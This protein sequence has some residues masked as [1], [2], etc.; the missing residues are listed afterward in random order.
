[1]SWIAITEDDVKTRLAGAELAAYKSA[2]LAQ[3][4]A[5]PLPEV[6][7]QVVSEVR[8]YIAANQRNFLSL[9]ELIPDKLLSATLA[10]IRYRLL[11]RL[12]IPV[13]EDRKQESEAAI[14]LL[15]RVADGK[16]AIEEPDDVS[17]DVLP[18]PAPRITTP[19]R[20][21]SQSAQDGI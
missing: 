1:M 6:I 15:E 19:T 4:Q 9:G 11:T 21:F 17:D 14:R 13:A 10:I 5:N 3:G 18:A 12:P 20:R 2:A 16:F 8:G 7:A